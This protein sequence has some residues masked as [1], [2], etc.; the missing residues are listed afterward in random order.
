M[1]DQVIA[2]L[3]QPHTGQLERWTL[4]QIVQIVSIRIAAGDGEDT[5]TQDVRY[6][7]IDLHRVA[8]VGDHGGRCADEVKAL[9]H[10][11]EQQDAAIG[12]D[13]SGFKAGGDVLLA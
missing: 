9:V 7:L 12:T 4:A 5:S 8:V 6:G 1:Q 11:R 10:A 2:A 3:C 13:L